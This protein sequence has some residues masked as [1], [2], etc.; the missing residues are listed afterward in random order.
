[1]PE[2]KIII[3]SESNQTYPTKIFVD[4]VQI[5]LVQQLRFEADARNQPAFQLEITFP[6]LEVIGLASA[7]LQEREARYR[8]L[9]APFLTK[10]ESPPPREP[11][12]TSWARIN[13]GLGIEDE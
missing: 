1:M 6:P 7:D 3:S 13:N 9:V 2:L 12:P 4:D 8:A 5:G 10:S 11:S